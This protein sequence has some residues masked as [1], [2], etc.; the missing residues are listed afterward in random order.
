ML[1]II[2]SLQ[3]KIFKGSFL[4]ACHHLI[5]FQWELFQQELWGFPG[6]ASG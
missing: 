4:L 2:F 6:G 3:K 5:Q 1:Q